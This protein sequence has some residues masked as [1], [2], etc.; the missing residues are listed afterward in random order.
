MKP[1]AL[2]IILCFCTL[3]GSSQNRFDDWN[4]E[5]I[6]VIQFETR[7]VEGKIESMNFDQK[8]D[9]D[10]I[11]SFLRNT[12]F[13]DIENIDFDKTEVLNQWI[14]RLTFKGQRDQIILCKKY[15]AIGK[16]IFSID[17][18]VTARLRKAI[19][20]LRKKQ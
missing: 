18:S 19:N 12:K 16:T 20:K 11:I 14:Y 6:T 17:E 13:R 5:K 2:L 8:Y 9:I 7:S 4:S 3:K 10:T 15:A 1:A